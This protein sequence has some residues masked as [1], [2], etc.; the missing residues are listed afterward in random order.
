MSLLQCWFRWTQ[1]VSIRT[2][3]CDVACETFA[4][5]ANSTPN[6]D[7]SMMEESPGTEHVKSN[8]TRHKRTSEYWAISLLAHPHLHTTPKYACRHIPKAQG[9]VHARHSTGPEH[10]PDN[11]RNRPNE[12]FGPCWT[13]YLL[14]INNTN[15]Y[16]CS[17]GYLC[18]LAADTIGVAHAPVDNLKLD[19]YADDQVTSR[20][21]IYI[22][23]N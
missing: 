23:W 18:T 13:S 17:A 1:L 8:D 11:T 14:M 22:R 7:R 10:K 3:F 5:N 16:D 9:F 12:N 6:S 20:E 21:K 19:A 2:T 4:T 15:A